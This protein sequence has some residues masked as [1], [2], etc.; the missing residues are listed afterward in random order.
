MHEG[1]SGHRTV[2]QVLQRIDELA[3]ERMQADD[4]AGQNV[5]GALVDWVEAMAP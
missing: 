2:A 3:E 4:E 1:K 5:L